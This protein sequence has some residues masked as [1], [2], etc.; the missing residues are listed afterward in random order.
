[1]PASTIQD[2]VRGA[3]KTALAS[4]SANVYDHVPESPQVPAVVRSCPSPSFDES[5]ERAIDHICR[6]VGDVKRKSHKDIKKR[7]SVGIVN[8]RAMNLK[9]N[10]L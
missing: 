10:L 8:L 4:V 2:D 9:S 1:M 3:I 7:V 5:L 6:Q